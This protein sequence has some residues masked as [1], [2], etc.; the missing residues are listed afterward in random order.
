MTAAEWVHST[1]QNLLVEW[2]NWLETT[3]ASSKESLEMAW[4]FY[5]SILTL[6]TCAHKGSVWE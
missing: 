4:C 6:F 2:M 3:P 1:M 5:R